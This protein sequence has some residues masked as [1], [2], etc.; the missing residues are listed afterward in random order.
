MSI[1]Y[2]NGEFITSSEARISPF[3]RGFLFADSVYEVT[4]VL[5]GCLVDFDRHYVRLERSCAAIGLALPLGKSDLLEAHANLISR[6]SVTEGIVYL[7]ISRGPSPRDFNID[8]VLTPT[9]FMFAETKTILD[10]PNARTGIRVISYPDERWSRCDVKTTQ[11]LTQSLARTAAI[12]AGVH[13][14]WFVKDGLVTEGSTN[15]AF[16]LTDEGKII[17][18]S[19]DD[20]IL[21]GITRQTI[22]D[23]A[24]ELGLSLET[25]AFSMDEAR[26]AKEAFS[27]SAST[28]IWPVIEIDG[29]MI[30]DG[31]PGSVYARLREHYIKN[32]RLKA[33]KD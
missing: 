29:T 4:S 24:N 32:A 21:P 23:C 30:G 19:T 5:E 1:V 20:N 25:R 31:K 33:P 8:P 2:L 13:D 6:N 22:I 3:D 12:K 18:R 9:V 28:F 14:A 17:T 15:N 26:A 10:H 7:Q 27:T 16:I 11:L